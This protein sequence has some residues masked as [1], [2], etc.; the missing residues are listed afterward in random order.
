MKKEKKVV[1]VFMVTLAKINT[2]VRIGKIEKQL[3]KKMDGKD[4]PDIN[5][6]K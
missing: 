4:F 5:G 6:H 1:L 2:Y 3:L